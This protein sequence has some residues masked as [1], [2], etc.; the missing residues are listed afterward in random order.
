MTVEKRI[1]DVLLSAVGLVVLSP[2]FVAIA[3]FIKLDDGGPV[4]FRQMRVGSGGRCFRIWKFRTMATRPGSPDSP[5]TVGDDPRVTRVGAWL[6][7]LKL[8]E[9]P[10]LL[11]VLRGEMSLVGP[12]PELPCYV[13]RYSAEER[14]VLNLMP[15]IT[16][17]G[18]LRYWNESA[19]LAQ[20]ED[21]ER[22]FVEVIMP[23]K[24]RLNLAYG[25]RATLWTDVRLILR[26]LRHLYL[27]SAIARAVPAGGTGLRLGGGAT[28]T[29]STP[30]TNQNC[31]RL[32]QEM[33]IDA[34]A[35]VR[36]RTI[37]NRRWRGGRR[38]TGISGAASIATNKQKPTIP[39]S[40]RMDRSTW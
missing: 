9:L 1:F 19:V 14:R 32:S 27:S 38:G 8:D 18:S 10:Q 20:A 4:F 17:E 33:D 24:I 22:A 13:A 34:T 28:C 39:S 31:L 29:A 35:R 7:R 30:K 36:N 2:L 16:S 21:P 12:R 37:E 5:L 25:D 15:G 3:L 11:N 26:T 23:E 40:T 6:R